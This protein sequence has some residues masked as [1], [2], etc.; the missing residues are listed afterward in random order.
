MALYFERAE[1]EK[2]TYAAPR[3]DQGLIAIEWRGA[4]MAFV[5]IGPLAAEAMQESA[6]RAAAQTPVA[7]PPEAKRP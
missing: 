5:L 3:A 7:A 4:A 2:A 1:P 6:E